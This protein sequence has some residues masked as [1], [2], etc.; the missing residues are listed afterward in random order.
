YDEEVN[1]ENDRESRVVEA[2]SVEQEVE[3]INK[4]EVRRALKRMKRGKAVGP[5]D[6]PVEVWKCLGE[7][8]VEFLTRLFNNILE[9]ER[10]PEEWRRS[11]HL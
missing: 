10:M 8:A 2:N 5:D 4:G 9:S 3:S 7:M 1:K 6:I 11:E